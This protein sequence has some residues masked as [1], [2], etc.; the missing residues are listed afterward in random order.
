MQAESRCESFVIETVLVNPSVNNVINPTVSIIMPTYNAAQYVTASIDSALN[1]TYKSAE[2]IVVDDGS[3]DETVERVRAYGNR[4]TLYQQN[5]AGAAVA[6]NQ[7]AK[8]AIGQWL[9]FL[10]ADDLWAPDKLE[11]QLNH[12]SDLAWSHTDWFFIGTGQSGTITGSSRAPQYGGSILPELIVCNFIGTSTLIVRR[13]VF[14]E[15]GGFDPTLRALQ[16]WD[17]WLR[18]ASK[19]DLAY[20]ADPLVYY[21]VHALSTSRSPR[22]TEPYHLELIKRTFA[23]DGVGASMPHL[24]KRALASSYGALT[25]IGEESRDYPFALRCAIRSTWHY[26]W[27]IY[28][29]K[30]ILRIALLATMSLLRNDQG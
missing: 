23:P 11:R 5:N 28:R 20:L 6:R 12:V 10:D 14:L 22:K 15:M 9:A 30:S 24:R 7:G 8:L 18:I 19:Y 13:E 29:W 3:T 16:D 26:P 17:L 25:V 4:V 2:I 21:R 1:Q 27:E